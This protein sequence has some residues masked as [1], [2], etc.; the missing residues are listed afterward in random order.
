MKIRNLIFVSGL[1]ICATTIVACASRK[2]NNDSKNDE[3][4]E[5]SFSGVQTANVDDVSMDY[6]SFGN[7]NKP[8][9]M[10][11]GISVTSVMPNSSAIMKQYSGFMNDYK[12]YVF[13]RRKNAPASYSI[14]DMAEDSYKVLRELDIKD[15][16][17][18]GASQGA[19]IGMCIA[20]DHP[21]MVH[22]LCACST[23]AKITSSDIKKFKVGK[24]FIKNGDVVGLNTYLFSMF[25]SED[26][27]N[28][29][30][31]AFE[32]A[33][34]NGSPEHL[35]KFDIFV[36]AQINCDIT[37]KL[38]NIK[39]PVFVVASKGDKLLGIDSANFLIEQLNCESYIYEKYG[40]AVYDEA[41]DFPQRM[42][43]F[44][45]GA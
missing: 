31:E 3:S 38:A 27:L 2:N 1:A 14:Q 11:P 17:I 44:F 5:N 21:E 18:F 33:K 13:D 23:T 43:D 34:T 29:N 37:D 24:E 30:K 15:A 42:L 22:S 12:V 32:S 19:C 35:Q 6:F 39:C 28:A 45:N 10:F 8:F 20:A 16:N 40:H 25:Y 26:F 4:S 9:V 7:G 36:D 41:P